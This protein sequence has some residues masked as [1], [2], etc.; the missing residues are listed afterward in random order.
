MVNKKELDDLKEWMSK[1]FDHQEKTIEDKFNQI[2]KQYDDLLVET[3]QTKEK[4]EASLKT[5][6][7]QQAANQFDISKLSDEIIDL[8]AENE[9]YENKIT[10]LEA[11]LHK[12]NLRFHG[13]KQEGNESVNDCVKSF[14]FNSLKIPESVVAKIEI[15]QSFRIGKPSLVRPHDT[16][17]ILA[18]F[19]RLGD[20]ELILSAARKKSKGTPGG[21]QEDLPFEWAK[22]RSDLYKRFVQPAREEFGSDKVRI[23]WQETTLFIN[24]TKIN[25]QEEW[26]TMKTKIKFERV[27]H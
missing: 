16:R 17:T 9:K 2:S 20:A 12:N 18:K 27:S 14:L 10:S 23:K 1:R 19:L 13:L 7:E 11:Q 5:L 24:K 15:V 3:R 26:A 22:I 25:P 6:N 4:H 8:K 21:V